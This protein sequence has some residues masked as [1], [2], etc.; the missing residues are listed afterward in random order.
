MQRGKHDGIVLIW[1]WDSEVVFFPDSYNTE[2]GA[3]GKV[4]GAV[5]LRKRDYAHTKR[6]SSK[7][8]KALCRSTFP[9]MLRIH[10]P[11]RVSSSIFDFSLCFHVVKGVALAFVFV[12][13]SIENK[14]RKVRL[15]VR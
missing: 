1:A 11:D 4:N 9:A 5:Y 10:R 3:Q 12:R 2:Y 8:L 15:S 13:Q 6:I 7:Y 14:W